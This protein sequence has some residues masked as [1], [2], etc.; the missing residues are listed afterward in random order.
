[1]WASSAKVAALE[2]R[3]RVL[4]AQLAELARVTGTELPA[5]LPV[6]DQVRALAAGGKPIQAIKALREHYPGLG[7]AEAKAAVDN[8]R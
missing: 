3:V 2:H 1:M 7:L 5:G 6:P 4:E 8:L